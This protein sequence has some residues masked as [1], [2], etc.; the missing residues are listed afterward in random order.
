M[1][2]RVEGR[3][4]LVTGGGSGMGRVVS[5]ALAK[6]GAGVTIVD[7][8]A[9]AAKAVADEIIAAG[10][11]AVSIAGNVTERADVAKAVETAV[12]AFGK[13]DVLFAI[14]GMIKPQKFLEIT[15]DNFR[16]TLDVNALGTLIC[17][18]EAA[19]QMIKQGHGGKLIL[20]SSIAGRQ[21]YGNFGSYCVSKFGVIALNQSA[22]NA[23]AE[24]HITS[25][26][27]APGVVDTPLWKKLDEDL[28]EI[29]A[30]AKV[31][32]AWDEFSGANLIGR[33]GVAE[34]VIGTALFL[35]SSDSDYMTGQVMMIDGG[36]V[37]V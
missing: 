6:E 1:S 14:A 5:I 10:G 36:M 15:E 28:V 2:G 24:H 33:K 35:A 34:D 32:Q 18:Q 8:N 37:L 12:E 30:S 20:T 7:L 9:D 17:Q 27:F 4:I 29:G 13:L 31:G 21:G 19:K 26:A 22:A 23:L 3:S 16:L 11:K 25:N